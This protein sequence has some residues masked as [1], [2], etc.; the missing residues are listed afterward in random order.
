MIENVCSAER[1]GFRADP[2]TAMDGM[3][4]GDKVGRA[5]TEYPTEQPVSVTVNVMYTTGPSFTVQGGSIP[6]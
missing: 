2:A 3:T 1:L 4:R 5:L 6:A